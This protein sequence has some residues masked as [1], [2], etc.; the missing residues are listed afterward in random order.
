MNIIDLLIIYLSFGAPC[1]VYFFFQNRTKLDREKLLLKSFL[2]VFVWIPYAFRLLHDFATTKLRMSRLDAE[3]SADRKLQEIQKQLS[4]LLVDS[5][6]KVS[7]F[8]F[9]EILDRYAG[10]SLACNLIGK[11]PDNSQKEFFRVSLHRHIEVGAMCLH[12]RNS[13]RLKFHQ[14]L[15]SNDF[16]HVITKLNFSVSDSEKLRHL[17]VEFVKILND[18]DTQKALDEIFDET[19]QSAGNFSV[20]ASEKDVWK[21]R[22]H[23]Q[24]STKQVPMH[25]QTLKM[26]AT[27]EKD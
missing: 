16:L 2:T 8:E 3:F 13:L 5:S 25:L 23:K 20:K 21:S 4:L 12:R 27:T 22:E 14:A 19:L 15:A 17:T 11:K 18:I 9:R 10:L 1:G 26:T 7:L 6:V 24:L